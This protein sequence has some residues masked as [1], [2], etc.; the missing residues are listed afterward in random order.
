MDSEN[1]FLSFIGKH[2]IKTTTENTALAIKSTLFWSIS[3]SD[4]RTSSIPIEWLI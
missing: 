2:T 1:K 4:I 3:V